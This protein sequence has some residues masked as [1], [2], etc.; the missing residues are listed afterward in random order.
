VAGAIAVVR[1]AASSEVALPAAPLGRRLAS[2]GYEALLIFALLFL[3]ALGYLFIAAALDLRHSRL[4]FQF[5]LV[6]VAAAYFIWHWTRGQ[7]LPMKTWRIRLLTSGGLPV[8]AG[9]AAVRFLAAACGL[10]TGGLTFAWALVDRDG[11]FLHDRVA[12]T[13]LVRTD[14]VR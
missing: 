10:A 6:A 11:R 7:T 8:G 1:A 3:T 13:Q 9:R 14:A 12:G 5:F 2:L 4:I